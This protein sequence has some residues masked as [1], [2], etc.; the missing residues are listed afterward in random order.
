MQALG[1]K[2]GA[3][4]QSKFYD[5]ILGTKEGANITCLRSSSFFSYKVTEKPNF[6]ILCKPMCVGQ[7]DRSR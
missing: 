2:V 6:I 5:N 4:D 3:P 7:K 1:A